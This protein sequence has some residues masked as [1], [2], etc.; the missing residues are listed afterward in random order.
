[1]Q[2]TFTNTGAGIEVV[3]SRPVIINQVSTVYRDKHEYPPIDIT[4]MQVENINRTIA[5]QKRSIEDGSFLKSNML[6]SKS[7]QKESNPHF[8][9]TGQA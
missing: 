3:A 9:V 7:R 2:M 8:M 6:T 4:A 5:N 1:M